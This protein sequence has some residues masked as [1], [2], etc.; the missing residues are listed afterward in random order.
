MRYIIKADGQR[1]FPVHSDLS[2]KE[3]QEYVRKNSKSD[4]FRVGSLEYINPKVMTVEDFAD[5]CPLIWLR[6]GEKHEI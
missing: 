3:L 6:G 2:L 5:C 4:I 1:A